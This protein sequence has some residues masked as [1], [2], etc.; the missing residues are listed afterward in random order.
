MVLTE[1][2][3]S[4]CGDWEDANWSHPHIGT[5][6]DRADGILFLV[7]KQ[8]CPSHRIGFAEWMPGRIGHLRIHYDKR[9]LDL[10]GCYQFADT[11]SA[12]RTK[13]RQAFWTVLDQQLALL[14]Q[15]NS[16][17]VCGDFNCSL[18]ADGATVGTS[19]FTWKETHLRGPQHQDMLRFQDILK[20]HS[21]TAVNTWN[22]KAPPTFHSSFQ[23][24]RIDFFLMRSADVD[25]QAL[26][27]KF[28]PEAGF[29]PLAGPQHCPMQCS[30]R[31]IP[32]RHVRKTTI[33]SC[34]YQQRLQCRLVCQRH[35]ELW[36]LFLED[37]NRTWIEF[38][39]HPCFPETVIDDMHIALMPVLQQH[40]PKCAPAT[41]TAPISL[42]QVQLK[43]HHRHEL[44][45]LQGKGQ[46]SVFQAWFH[47]THFHKLKREH[48]KHARAAKRQRFHD[49][50]TDVHHAS[51]AH[52]SF[53]IYQAVNK[54]TP[55]QTKKRIRLRTADG[56]IAD[57]T[58]AVELYRQHIHNV[59]AGPARVQY[60]CLE[61]PGIPFSQEELADEIRRIP[62]LKS[63][64]RPYVP[65]IY[66]K[67]HADQTAAKI[68]EY[69][70]DWWGKCDFHIPLQWKQS[71][72]TFINK[73]NK[74]PDRLMHLQRLALQEPIGKCVLAL[75]NRKLMQDL[76]PILAPWP[77]FAFC[78]FRSPN[79][80]IKRVVLH[81]QETRQLMR[82]QV[83]DVHSRA[84]HTSRFQVCGGLQM[85]VDIHQAFDRI[86]RQRMF[87]FLQQQNLNPAILA[88]L[89]EWHSLTS[90]I[91][92]HDQAPH[93]FQTGRAVRQGCRIAPTLW[94]SY[95]IALFQE[96]A[97]HTSVSWVQRCV[98]MFADDLHSG[99]IFR[100]AAQL[101]AALRG[102]G[103]IL[104]AVEAM[105][106][107]LSLDKTHVLIHICGT[108]C[109]KTIQRIVRTDGDGSYI[110]VPRAHGVLSKL[111]VK[112]QAKYLGVCVSYSASEKLTMQSRLSSAN[113]TFGRLK[114]WLCSKRLRLGLRLQ[115]W[116]ACVFMTLQYGLFAV[117]L[118]LPDILKAQH[119]ILA[120]Y[121]QMVGDHSYVTHHTHAHILEAHG[122]KHPINLLIRAA[123]KLQTTLG[124]RLNFLPPDDILRTIDW[125]SL[126]Q[127]IQLLQAALVMQT[128][129]PL[130]QLLVAPRGDQVS[131]SMSV[132]PPAISLII[133]F[134][135]PSN[136]CPSGTAAA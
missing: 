29:L 85:F 73:P 111:P 113:T 117:D 96:L 27:V 83:R 52:D 55:K 26:D 91:V 53:T 104:D 78:G 60:E 119:R 56:G 4:F 132:V 63:V 109:R 66:W 86:P 126:P 114:K 135:T 82:T 76:M 25:R 107:E 77:Q 98:T 133:Q 95:T 116:H 13:Q 7:S 42:S 72:L 102:L 101:D 108:N 10:I 51:K 118:T 12:T 124:R 128:Q 93:E 46:S 74:S 1:T 81:C 32:Y 24:S 38:H 18:T 80:A 130:R 58:A 79:D 37:M 127:T 90:Y 11:R 94:T 57:T 28:F 30:I 59:W 69:L 106:L 100:S 131:V 44:R 88:L 71:W 15:R 39:A 35:P 5:Q 48:Q 49:L 19:S 8:T 34:T 87:D 64:A 31:K 33:S 21:L 134:E 97:Q 99:Q 40:F 110:E 70:T 84:A 65:G 92:W 17:L 125:N 36:T 105:G 68:Y 47:L 20:H 122:L 123:E 43:W 41:P 2:R 14:P 67:F 50:L 6:T 22:A 120:M 129:V 9:S 61:P 45:R 16:L 115:I 62:V 112:K 103:C 136:A 75:L 23:A 89:A 54:F 121:R 3:W